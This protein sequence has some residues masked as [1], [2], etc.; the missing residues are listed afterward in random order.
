MLFQ[1]TKSS[2][3]NLPE[4]VSV[5]PCLWPYP[6][7]TKSMLLVLVEAQ[8]WMQFSSC[9]LGQRKR[10]ISLNS[11]DPVAQDSFLPLVHQCLAGSWSAWCPPGP[12]GPS[13]QICLPASFLCVLIPRLFLPKYCTQHS[14]DSP[15]CSVLKPKYLWMAAQPPGPSD[16][17]TGFDLKNTVCWIWFIQWLSSIESLWVVVSK[18]HFQS[19]LRIFNGKTMLLCSNWKNII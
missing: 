17:P 19:I 11:A 14:C 4:E 16:I 8:N 15:A 18:E 10:V 7:F 9:E 2:S 5:F 13:V 12:S 1:Q 3:S 6:G